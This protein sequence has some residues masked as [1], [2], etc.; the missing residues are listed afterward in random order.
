MKA[1]QRL[2][3]IGLVLLTGCQSRSREHEPPFV[4]VDSTWRRH[5]VA[6]TPLTVLLPANFRKRNDYGCFNDLP[7]SG[8][9]LIP[10][11]R[12]VCVSLSTGGLKKA[13]TLSD[14]DGCNLAMAQSTD[15]VFYEDVETQSVSLGTRPAILQ[16]G[17]RT[18]S[19]D[20][21]VRVPEVLVNVAVTPDS[22]AVVHFTVRSFD[23]LPLAVL[24]ATSVDRKSSH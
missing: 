9:A 1:L 21:R 12:D 23:D 8:R 13:P 14:N 3:P 20:H 22:V 6:G 16:R 4:A 10:D 2:L 15:C 7:L 19:I 17:F 24:V 18:G 11:I 5:N